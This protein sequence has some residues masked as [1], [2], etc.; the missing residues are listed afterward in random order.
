MTP[1]GE[2]IKTAQGAELAVLKAH[3]ALLVAQYGTMAAEINAQ[4]SKI[5]TD[6]EINISARFTAGSFGGNSGDAGD[7]S[8]GN[9]ATFDADGNITAGN[10]QEVFTDA[11]GNAFYDPGHNNP[12]SDELQD[13]V[14]QGLDSDGDGISD[15]DEVSGA[16]RG[17]LIRG[18][19]SPLGRMIR[20]GENNTDEGIFPLPRGGCWTRCGTAGMR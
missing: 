12:V 8:G 16:R 5:V 9:T 14:N 3:Q 6:V 1:L 13:S 10:G 18:V 15:A 7:A 20:V 19:R 2:K 17:A 11:A 4:T